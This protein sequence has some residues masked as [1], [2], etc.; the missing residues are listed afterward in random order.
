MVLAYHIIFTAYGFWL[1]ND[2]R[3]SWSNF[4]ASWDLVLAGGKA[5]KTN[6]A[7][8]LAHQSHDHVHRLEAK[9]SL[10]F[11]AVEFSGKQALSISKG[12]I[13]AINDA[14]YVVH[15][16]S[17]LPGHVHLVMARMERNVKIV[18]EPLKA[19]ASHRLRVEGHHPFVEYEKADG[20]LPTCWGEGCWKVFL[21]DEDQVRRAIDYVEQNPVKE[22]KAIHRWSFVKGIH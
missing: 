19:K 12:F 17:I 1:P 16:C 5:T 3:G 9:K 7:K 11:P 4:V 13:E 8:S 14:A 20:S 18:V 21:N 10:K 15:A 2:P 22:G 6:E